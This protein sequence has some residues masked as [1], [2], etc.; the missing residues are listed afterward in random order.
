MLGGSERSLESD[1]IESAPHHARRR[2]LWRGAYCIGAV[3]LVGC[4]AAIAVSPVAR[5]SWAWLYWFAA[6]SAVVCV[7]AAVQ[8]WSYER[9]DAADDG[10]WLARVGTRS[11][12]GSDNDLDGVDD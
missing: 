3:V 10:A 12:K 1:V 2:R 9:Y 5:S 7:V 6:A 8:L 4:L 11:S